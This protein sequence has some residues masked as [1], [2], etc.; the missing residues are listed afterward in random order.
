[1]LC[2][3]P[4]KSFP[5]TTGADMGPS[6]GPSPKEF[7]PATPGPVVP[8]RLPGPSGLVSLHGNIGARG[9]GTLIPSEHI[10]NRLPR[11]TG[12]AYSS[13]D[14]GLSLTSSICPSEG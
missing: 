3:P 7:F 2:S 13:K 8:S 6:A 5:L 4:S 10:S 12:N 11:K 1:M 14:E 9:R